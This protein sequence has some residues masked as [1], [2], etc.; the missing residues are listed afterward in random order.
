MLSPTSVSPNPVK[1]TS[2]TFDA[3]LHYAT[4]PAGTQIVFSVTGA[5]P[6]TQQV[7]INGSGQA[8]FSYTAV[9]RALTL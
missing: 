3:T 2:Q 1:G 6:Q 4:A 9:H 5:N 8:S 7:V